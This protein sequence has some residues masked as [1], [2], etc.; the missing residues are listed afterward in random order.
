[1]SACICQPVLP[2][3]RRGSVRPASAFLTSTSG[4]SLFAKPQRLASLKAADGANAAH[5]ASKVIVASTAGPLAPSSL[6]SSAECSQPEQTYDKLIA[7]GALKANTPL[8]RAILL[9]LLA[10]AFI[11]FGAMMVLAVGA[12]CPG[13]ASSNPGLQRLIQGAFGLPMGLILVVLTG[14]ELFTGNT[15]LMPLAV[16]EGRSTIKQLLTNWFVSFFGNLAGSIAVVYLVGTS[17]L[18]ASLSAPASVAATKTSLTFTQAFTRGIIANWLVCL[19][20][21]MT[22]AASSLPGKALG[23]WFPV[24]AFSSAGGEHSVANMFSIPMGIY[25]AGDVSWKSF[26]GANLLP[27]VLGNIVSGVLFCALAFHWC[28]GL[29][30][31]SATA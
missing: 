31:R 4:P 18:F 25:L 24:T 23:A 28:Y 7:L 16:L 5:R 11:S 8:P 30:H 1:M 17:G 13:L 14:A 12:S 20:V 9:S 21:W 26:F 22:A 6:S 10:G 2:C 27:V 29:R 15:M 19:G 3:T